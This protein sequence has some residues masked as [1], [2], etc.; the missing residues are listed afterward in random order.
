VDGEFR[1]I[2]ADFESNGRKKLKQLLFFLWKSLWKSFVKSQLIQ[3]LT[4]PQFEA[5]KKMLT[6]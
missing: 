5:R 2:V 1:V 3:S 6:P 4:A